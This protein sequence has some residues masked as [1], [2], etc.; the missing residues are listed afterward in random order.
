MICKVYQYDNAP[1]S[2]LLVDPSDWVINGDWPLSYARKNNLAITL[3]GYIDQPYCE[4]YNKTLN[5]FR[6][7]ERMIADRC[8]CC[9]TVKKWQK[10]NEDT[11]SIRYSGEEKPTPRVD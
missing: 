10:V 8:Q 5:R 9:G 1:D 7:G 2:L 6:D 11:S 4:N 3:V